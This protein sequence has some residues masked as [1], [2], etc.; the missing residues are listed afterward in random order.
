M[1]VIHASS[2]NFVGIVQ[3]LYPYISFSV[4]AFVDQVS[5]H[6]EDHGY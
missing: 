5:E 6:P 4:F 3:I 1:L 2:N